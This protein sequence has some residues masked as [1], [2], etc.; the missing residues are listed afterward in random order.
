MPAAARHDAS[1]EGHARG[2]PDD[3]VRS[4]GV[5]V[6]HAR[7]YRC[8]VPGC[9]ASWPPPCTPQ[10]PGCGRQRRSRAACPGGQRRQSRAPAAVRGWGGVH[11]GTCLSTSRPRVWPG[12]TRPL[13]GKFQA[14]LPA[15]PC[16]TWF[17][18]FMKL[19]LGCQPSRRL[20]LSAEAKKW[21]VLQQ[22]AGPTCR[23]G[24][25]VGHGHARVGCTAGTGTWDYLDA[26]G[27]STACRSHTCCPRRCRLG[28][29]GPAAVWGC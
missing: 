22:E 13:G 11:R 15:G 27:S 26:R 20:A 24:G 5:W 17:T 7:W 28:C 9:V 23:Q 18:S 1:A 10:P 8:A 12:R 6:A 19:C 29:T 2:P 4:L 16:P 3:M 14:R 21:P 25:M